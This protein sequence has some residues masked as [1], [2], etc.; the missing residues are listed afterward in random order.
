MTEQHRREIPISLGS[1]PIRID[2]DMDEFSHADPASGPF[3]KP[4]RRLAT[5]PRLKAP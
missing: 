5:V 3:S 1:V 2:A 4:F